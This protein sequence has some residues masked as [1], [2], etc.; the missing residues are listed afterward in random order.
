[1]A[2][3]TVVS[4]V[5]ALRGLPGLRRLKFRTQ[6]LLLQVGVVLLVVVGVG[7]VSLTAQQDRIRDASQDRMVNVARSVATLPTVLQAMEHDPAPE[8]VIQPLA[9]LIRKSS[10]V[11][12]VVVSNAQGLRYSHPNP[13]QLLKPV[14]TDPREVLSGRTFTGTQ[15]GSLGRSWRVKMPIHSGGDPTAPVIGM[16]SVGILESQLSADLA[17]GLPWLLTWLTIA[18]VVG[19]L[20]AAW[21][22][23]VVWR[24][25]HRL[26]PEEIAA[27][28]QSKEAILDGVSEGVIA[29]DRH[30][31]VALV[32]HEAQRMLGLDASVVGRAAE[33]VLDATVVAFIASP[34]ADSSVVLAGESVLVAQRRATPL[35][36]EAI[37]HVLILRDR[38]ELREMVRSLDGARDL[39]QALR[40]QGHEFSNRMH[41]VSGLLE[42]GRVEEAV[43]FINRDSPATVTAQVRA[44]GIDDPELEALLLQKGHLG[45][46]RDVA[47]VIDQSSRHVFEGTSDVLTVVA[48]LVDNALDAVVCDGTVEVAVH[49]EADGV[50]IV[51][52]DDGP[53]L[54]ALDATKIFE[55]GVTTKDSAARVRGI[56]LALVHRITARRQGQAS[57]GSS[58][59]GGARV[60]VFLPYV[61]RAGAQART[62][63]AGQ[64][65]RA[66]RDRTPDQARGER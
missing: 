38:T 5:T 63:W 35:T 65:A 32:N 13:E 36:D 58:S 49:D 20:L 15:T 30:G 24:R 60:E 23:R 22:A 50:R 54:G 59:S 37:G 66:G 31:R 39:A 55:V 26:E 33:D 25:I 28:L 16:V 34:E 12:Y 46:E 57:A 8:Q 1:M 43:R 53:G 17:D 4:F 29:L 7:A 19:T 40:A 14:S 61:A 41:V 62:V 51:V 27:L 2:E 47:V 21:L 45:A 3:R 42:L 9:E 11:T 6:V 10:G 48:N 52:S 64:R 18:A 44:P 56:G